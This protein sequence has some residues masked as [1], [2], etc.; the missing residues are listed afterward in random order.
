MTAASY[1]YNSNACMSVLLVLHLHS[2]ESIV[3][4]YRGHAPK[5]ALK[6]HYAQQQ[7]SR[8]S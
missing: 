8:A 6:A 4:T 3:N 5:P 7:F 2:N 1:E